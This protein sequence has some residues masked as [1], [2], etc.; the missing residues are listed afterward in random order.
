MK[1]KKID[2]SVVRHI[3]KLSRLKLDEK[4]LTKFSSQLEVI[5][6]Y[7][8]KLNEVDTSKVQPTS[9]AASSIENVFRKD[10]LKPSLTPEEALKNAPKKTNGYF[11]V[12]KVIE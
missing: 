12:P 6:S 1:N 4:E 2:E 11:I 8:D 7:I 9:H 10:E 5:L 3:A